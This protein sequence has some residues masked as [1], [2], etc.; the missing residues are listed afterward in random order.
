MNVFEQPKTIVGVLKKIMMLKEIPLSMWTPSE[1]VWYKETILLSLQGIE[2]DPGLKEY[3]LNE[4]IKNVP[5]NRYKL[6]F[7]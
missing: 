5:E 6:L 7:Q 3:I 2:V 1:R 4:V